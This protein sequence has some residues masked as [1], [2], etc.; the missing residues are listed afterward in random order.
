MRWR[1]A[2]NILAGLFLPALLL[3]VNLN[4]FPAHSQDPT[5]LSR[6]HGNYAR[7]VRTGT[8]KAARSTVKST[9]ADGKTY[10][11]LSSPLPDPYGAPSQLPL[12][13]ENGTGKSYLIPGIEIPSFV[14]GLNLFS[15]LAFPNKKDDG[16]K[17]YATTPSTFW[18][19]L[20]HGP[21][22]IDHDNFRV[23]QLMHPYQGSIYHGFARST[24]LNYWESFGYTF[25]GSVLWELGG[26]TTDP[27]INDQ[28]ASG[29]SGTFF[30]EALF[31]MASLLLEGHER[32][33]FWRE[34]AAAV[35]SP[36]L[37]L[38]RLVFGERFQAVFPSRSPATFWR[39]R[40]GGTVN[41]YSG[42][43]DLQGFRNNEALANYSILYGL[44]GKPGYRYDRPFDYFNFDLTLVN[45]SD[46]P[47]E[48]VSVSGLLF[49]HRYEAG[50]SCRGIWGLFGGYDY[51]SPE[52]FRVSSTAVSFGT[53]G[54]WWLT[55]LVALQATALAGAGYGA[56]GNAADRRA[57]RDY[58]YGAMGQGLL[59]LR[60]IL[61]DAASCNA[62]FRQYFVTGLL[63]DESKRRESINRLTLA[64]TV[65]IQDRHAVGLQYLGSR[66]N[67]HFPDS[68]NKHQK[69]GA[70][71]L[72]YT[73]LG[74]TSLG[75]VEWRYR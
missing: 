44:P 10:G 54:Q 1:T 31:R 18:E 27:S 29:I 65:P 26:E 74:D 34:L 51:I 15:R 53:V 33:G 17:T 8:I 23:N 69:M 55:R 43:D 41:S 46:N 19:H 52:I 24:G 48:N 73:F 57:E 38:N 12:S 45:N 67:G 75:A 66:R 60:L 72:V 3:S 16:E 28:V 36:S 30:G 49:G 4:P 25:M 59:S 71:T 9:P 39:V 62:T 13:W 32:P 20:T 21:W 50:D 70:W 6:F 5:P 47:L 37:G 56:G 42:G 35:I 64:I 7:T 2:S 58:H 68:G 14:L 22:V 40:L 63:S 61:G 11:I